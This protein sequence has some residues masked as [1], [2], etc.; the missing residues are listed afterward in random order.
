MHPREN[1]VNPTTNCGAD[2]A[3][4]YHLGIQQTR[5]RTIADKQRQVHIAYTSMPPY[6]K[7]ILY[8]IVQLYLHIV[9]VLPYLLSKIY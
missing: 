7:T 8:Y 5:P 3:T 6:M 1:H 9:Y 4:R 2:R